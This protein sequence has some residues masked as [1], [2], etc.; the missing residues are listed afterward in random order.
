ME[1]HHGGLPSSNAGVDPAV[2]VCV[3]GDRKSE[4]RA[5]SPEKDTI[6]AETLLNALCTETS[7]EVEP[8][9]IFLEN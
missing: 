2:E 7:I 5:V 4:F 9:A 6:T 3:E 1:G 8:E